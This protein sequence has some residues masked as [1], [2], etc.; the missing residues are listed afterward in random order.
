MEYEPLFPYAKPDKKAWFVTCG[1][2]VTLSDGTGIVHIAPAFGEDDAQ[3][4]HRY[5]LPFVQLV[6]AKGAFVGGTPWD[7][8]FVKEGGSRRNRKRLKA[9]GKWF[10]SLRYT[11]SYP[12]CWRCDT[13]LLYYAKDTW[14]I[15]MTKVR[16]RL[17]ANNKTV[18]WLPK[19]IGERRFGDWLENVIDWGV[20]RDRY[21]GTPLNIWECRLR[22]SGCGG[23]HRGAE[24]D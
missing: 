15:A 21:W 4:G 10:K 7:G 6:D 11:H 23:Q 19:S 18:N 16:D 20:S 5:D 22:A 8:M 14:F 24:R 13:P 1:D 12:H 2:Y 3:I 17:L 9:E